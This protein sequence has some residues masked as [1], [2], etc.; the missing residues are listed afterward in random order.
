MVSVIT[1]HPISSKYSLVSLLENIKL[2][3]RNELANVLPRFRLIAEA[4]L[5]IDVIRWNSVITSA[6]NVE[7]G[8]IRADGFFLSPEKV[9]VHISCDPRIH[10]HRV[11]MKESLDHLISL[12]IVHQLGVKEPV[13][14]PETRCAAILVLSLATVTDKAEEGGDLRVTEAT[15]CGGVVIPSGGIRIGLVSGV[16]M[17]G[18]HVQI[19]VLHERR[20][21]NDRHV[22]GI[23][24]VLQLCDADAT[25]LLVQT[26]VSPFGVSAGKASCVPV[27]VS[28]PQVVDHLE[29]GMLVDT[30]I[31]SVE[32]RHARISLTLSIP[33]IVSWRHDVTTALVWLSS[34]KS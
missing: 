11:I 26:L 10:H 9:V 6:L 21:E 24:D 5:Q 28:K 30:L 27:V 8:K 14:K 32:A 25:R 17:M 4:E 16:T 2:L 19:I 20:A 33:R 3:E 34:H 22:F 1:K 7:G 31:T 15:S 13:T 29:T 18:S 12:A 23:G